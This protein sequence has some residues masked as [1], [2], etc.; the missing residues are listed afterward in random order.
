MI[1]A[2]IV[3]GK[4]N[5]AGEDIPIMGHPPANTSD[6]TLESF[7]Q[8]VTAFNTNATNTTRKGVKLDF[9]TIEVFEKSI[10]IVSQFDKVSI[11]KCYQNTLDLYSLYM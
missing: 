7:L 4:L 2:D 5:G 3:L 1:E 9:K 10:Q 11:C 6:L 8:Q